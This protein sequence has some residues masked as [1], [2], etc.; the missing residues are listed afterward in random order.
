MT[1]SDAAIRALK[2]REKPYKVHDRDSL[3][4]LVNRDGSRLWR[5]R[6]RFNCKEKLMAL[7]DYPTVSLVQAREGQ[8]AAGLHR[9][10]GY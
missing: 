3:F 2:P 10:S 6:Y 8:F 5:W 1:L 4:L 9:V 7:G